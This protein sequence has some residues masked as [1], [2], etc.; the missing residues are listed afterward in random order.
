MTKSQ[1]KTSPWLMDMAVRWHG[2]VGGGIAGFITSLGYTIT[3]DKI[4]I[5]LATGMVCLFSLGG[6]MLGLFFEHYNPNRRG[7]TRSLEFIG[8]C[9]LVSTVVVAI[10]GAFAAKVLTEEC[11]DARDHG[12]RE[13]EL[14][15]HCRTFIGLAV[16]VSGG[17]ILAL[18]V[19]ARCFY[20]QM[21]RG[22][23]SWIKSLLTASMISVFIA[24]GIT[25][26]LGMLNIGPLFFNIESDKVTRHTALIGGAILGGAMGLLIGL[27]AALMIAFAPEQDAI[28]TV[29]PPL[30]T[31]DSSRL[32][33]SGALGVWREKLQF[34]QVQEAITTDAAQKFQLKKQIEEAKTNITELEQ[35]SKGPSLASP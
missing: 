31:T 28:P 6:F 25:V 32:P 19:S 20:L 10:L 14:Y 24:L 8:S 21:R 7:N 4:S 11:F 2:L 16:L 34:L 23:R 29:Q 26:L 13:K 18:S 17:E 9:S 5:P 35:A 22:Q 12:L 15:D 27:H 33:Q 1:N 3:G 30:P